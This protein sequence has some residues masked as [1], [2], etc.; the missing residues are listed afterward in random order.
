MEDNKSKGKK[1]WA[2]A[3]EQPAERRRSWAKFSSR[4]GGGSAGG[5]WAR[6]VA[7]GFSGPVSELLTETVCFHLSAPHRASHWPFPPSDLLILK[8]GITMCLPQRND[9]P[10]SHSGATNRNGHEDLWTQETKH[11]S[12]NNRKWKREHSVTRNVLCHM[13]VSEGYKAPVRCVT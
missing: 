10:V 12:K 2:E 8:E 7:A 11:T 3:R 1:Q 13:P 6:Q 5:R 4:C 9:W